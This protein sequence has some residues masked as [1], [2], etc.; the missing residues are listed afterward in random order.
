[1]C[2]S[3]E[4]TQ[5]VC[6]REQNRFDET[7]L[8][9]ETQY[10]V[11]S[12]R[13]FRFYYG[14][15]HKFNMGGELLLYADKVVEEI[16]EYDASTT[17]ADD[18]SASEQ[19][20]SLETY[21]AHQASDETVTEEATQESNRTEEDGNH[22]L[23]ATYEQF[24]VMAK[25]TVEELDA[26]VYR[27][28]KNQMA[29]SM[30]A[31]G[32]KRFPAVSNVFF[33]GARLYA[34]MLRGLFEGFVYVG[35]RIAHGNRVSFH[36]VWEYVD[37]IFQEY[38][39]ASS[40]L[41]EV[42]HFFMS[43]NM[44]YDYK[45]ARIICEASNIPNHIMSGSLKIT[46]AV[47][48]AATFAL[49]GNEHGEVVG[50]NPLR[51]NCSHGTYLTDTSLNLNPVCA[52]T[53]AIENLPSATDIK[54]V[55][56]LFTFSKFKTESFSKLSQELDIELGDPFNYVQTRAV[57][58]YTIR[59]LRTILHF[60]IKLVIDV[61]NCMMELVSTDDS[62]DEREDCVALLSSL[63]YPTFLI[64]TF[65]IVTHEAQVQLANVLT[66]FTSMIWS[67][68]YAATEYDPSLYSTV[69]N[70]ASNSAFSAML[71]RTMCAGLS[72]HQCVRQGLGDFTSP[73]RNTF[74][75]RDSDN[76]KRIVHACDR[77]MCH[78]AW[79]MT[80]NDFF[81]YR[82]Q[83]ENGTLYYRSH[84]TGDTETA[85]TVEAEKHGFAGFSNSTI[86]YYRQSA[87][88]VNVT[89]YGYVENIKAADLY[90]SYDGA[91]P[92][93]LF[94]KGVCMS[95][96]D[97][98]HSKKHCSRSFETY[99]PDAE[100][101]NVVPF[102]RAG[103]TYSSRYGCSSDAHH[104]QPYPLEAATSTFIVAALSVTLRSVIMANM[105]A[106]YYYERYMQKVESTA[107]AMMGTGINIDGNLD[108]DMDVDVDV[109]AAEVTDIA[110]DSLQTSLHMQLQR[111]SDYLIPI[112]HSQAQYTMYARDV[113]IGLLE[114]I[115]AM[116]VVL[117]EDDDAAFM[118]FQRV[119][120]ELVDMLQDMVSTL[121][122]AWLGIMDDM[123]RLGMELVSILIKAMQSVGDPSMASQL[124]EDIKT[125]TEIMLEIIRDFAMTLF[126]LVYRMMSMSPFGEQLLEMIETLCGM[127]NSLVQT[128]YTVQ[129][130]L[131]SVFSQT[132]PQPEYDEFKYKFK[133][134]SLGSYKVSIPTLSLK[135]KKLGNLFGSGFM[136]SIESM[137]SCHCPS[138][139]ALGR[140]PDSASVKHITNE[141]ELWSSIRTRYV[142]IARNSA[143][144]ARHVARQDLFGHIVGVTRR[145]DSAATALWKTAKG[146]KKTHELA[147]DPIHG[148][149][150]FG[151]VKHFY[152]MQ[153]EN[154]WHLNASF[155][156]RRE[157]AETK[158]QRTL[159]ESDDEEATQTNEIPSQTSN[160][161]T[162]ECD[163]YDSVIS[164]VDDVS[165]FG[166]RYY[167]FDDDKRSRSVQYIIQQLSSAA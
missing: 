106:Y 131:C 21:N 90:L 82:G 111:K 128:L 24:W 38:M 130:G 47:S 53:S 40:S 109:S 36:V 158:T 124:L 135:S 56:E 86:K 23:S 94:G 149:T 48:S 138:P 136:S 39:A 65:V 18:A 76:K 84:I 50:C 101:G 16:E 97:M 54:S 58:I 79:S 167:G 35:Y 163:V 25:D 92:Y 160:S 7:L 95:A 121:G 164:M 43:P 62:I 28:T 81:G 78:C 8:C 161:R 143:V 142:N 77:E 74:H 80:E 37:P 144:I 27:I 145:A 123:I 127:S 75:M 139:R 3:Y 68:M 165:S 22:S 2:A 100:K 11:G 4:D 60:A 52:L 14:D 125:A 10:A 129:D 155:W 112:L 12:T 126:Q 49:P 9:D 137:F 41:F 118:E 107:D 33:H 32:N 70:Q 29:I 44:A 87:R 122:S 141:T 156:T 105:T 64:N 69:S 83:G 26:S 98:T 61:L 120:V 102:V 151:K 104:I 162:E 93:R 85:S 31:L 133:F 154:K 72:H 152:R 71:P 115:R 6:G 42:L 46:S 51:T 67:F 147:S 146:M 34:E 1:M 89:K 13:P 45:S 113:I 15:N 110:F 57:S 19:I 17:T 88:G 153:Y 150:F 99:T 140:D 73:G 108:V 119:M 66:S 134:G 117:Q 91:F 116:V 114:W 148:S 63:T 103:C 30:R 5:R 20:S 157:S 96:C 166:V 159:L 55:A 59:L 132:I